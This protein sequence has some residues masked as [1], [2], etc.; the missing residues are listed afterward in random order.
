MPQFFPTP[1]ALAPRD[2]PRI[3]QLFY[4]LRSGFP[5]LPAGREFVIRQYAIAMWRSENCLNLESSFF[6]SAL[7]AEAA[8]PKSA[9]LVES[10]GPNIL[11]IRAMTRDAE[12]PNI[13]GKILRYQS[14][15]AKDLNDAQE[16]YQQLLDCLRTCPT[17]PVERSA[18]HSAQQPDQTPRNAQCS[19]G[20]G[21]KFKRCCGRDEAAVLTT[22]ADQHPESASPSHAGRAAPGR[23]ISAAFR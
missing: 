13:F 22:A 5:Q 3:Q 11:Q 1:D 21:L 8:Q 9:I 7:E 16:A 14:R 4:A 12:G 20:S 15:I 19:C 18:Q 23:S 6:A 17:A 2:Q 10:F